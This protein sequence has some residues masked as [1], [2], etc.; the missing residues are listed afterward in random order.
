M[1]TYV[2]GTVCLKYYGFQSKDIERVGVVLRI[3][4]YCTIPFT[5]IHVLSRSLNNQL[6]TIHA[7]TVRPKDINGATPKLTLNIL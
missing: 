5:D 1:H 2:F 7:A 6:W 3:G 4:T